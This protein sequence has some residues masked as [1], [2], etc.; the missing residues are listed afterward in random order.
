MPSNLRVGSS[1]SSKKSSHC[2][3]TDP[4]P[5]KVRKVKERISGLIVNSLP[6]QR[7]LVQW[8]TG[9]T[10]EIKSHNLKNEGEPTEESLKVV[11]LFIIGGE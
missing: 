3:T 1:V 7:W 10:E 9:E 4:P 8:A 2:R 11:R 6:D 5:G